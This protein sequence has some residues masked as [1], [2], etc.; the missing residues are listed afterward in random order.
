MLCQP[1][2]NVLV[3]VYWFHIRAAHPFQALNSV[4][5]TFGIQRPQFAF[6]EEN[7]DLDTKPWRRFL[8]TLNMRPLTPPQA[9]LWVLPH[10]QLGGSECG[11]L[12]MPV[13]L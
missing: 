13:E 4:L 10:T 2:E 1:C 3:C 6:Q 9:T 5:L 7:H 12:L 8:L 11:A